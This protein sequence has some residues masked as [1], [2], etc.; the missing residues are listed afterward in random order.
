M[1]RIDVYYRAEKWF[2][3]HIVE[4]QGI[5]VHSL[6]HITYPEVTGYYIPTLLKWGYKDEALQFAH[7]LIN[8]QREDG[9]WGDPDYNQPYVFDT[10]QILKG[11]LAIREYIPEAEQSVRRGADWI[12]NNIQSSG[13]LTTPYQQA[14]GDGKA[15]SELIHLYCLSPLIEYSEVSGNNQYK[16]AAHNVLKY[17]KDICYDQI[18]NFGLLSHFYAYVM[19]ALVDLGEVAMAKEAMSKIANLQDKRGAIPAYQD[20]KWVCSTGI[21]QF[22]LVWYKLGDIERG[23]K[24]FDYAC[25]LQNKSGGWYGG[26][27]SESFAKMRKGKYIPDYFPHAEIS[28]AVK[29]FL[30]ALSYKCEKEFE[31][32]APRFMDKID[33]QDGRYQ[34]ILNKICERKTFTK[35]LDVGC[36]KG[37]YI[38]NLMEDVENVEIAATDI[39]EN[40]MKDITTSVEKYK[41]TMTSLPFDNDQFD[42][43]YACEALEHAICIPNAVNELLRVTKSNGLLILIDKPV[44]MLGKLEI[45]PWEQWINTS[46]LIQIV[47]D[48]G[49]VKRIRNL[50]YENQ[51]QDGLFDAWIITK[52]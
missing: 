12:L 10:A 33:K 21:F 6:K 3:E 38:R 16:E 49:E 1:N 42:I 29:Y 37:R 48:K 8:N 28:W 24:A 7:W 20:A 19:E 26:Y 22:A 13:Q 25:S 14:W 17:Y 9:A 5:A 11:L 43:V 39:S 34:I 15:C 41:C 32:Q 44:E 47:G 46:E 27:V 30:D 51:K 18:M 52:K 36:G 31:D 35:V 50:S 40:V 23:N 4:N 2:K 45:D